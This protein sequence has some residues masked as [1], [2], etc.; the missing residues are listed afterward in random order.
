[1]NPLEESPQPE[2]ATHAAT[3]SLLGLPGPQ[4]CA[5]LAKRTDSPE[6][7]GLIFGTA[8]S[9]GIDPVSF[10]SEFHEGLKIQERKQ[11]WVNMAGYSLRPYQKEF[12]AMLASIRCDTP[13]Q[14]FG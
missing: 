11:E 13:F 8:L 12:I 14:N 10:I 4:R 7:A 3:F 9:A 2:L 1:M 5:E 6:H